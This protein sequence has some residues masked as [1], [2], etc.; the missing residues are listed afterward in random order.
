MGHW[1]DRCRTIGVHEAIR[2]STSIEVSRMVSTKL[3]HRMVVVVVVAVSMRAVH[4]IGAKII[5]RRNVLL[6]FVLCLLKG[7]VVGVHGSGGKGRGKGRC[8]VRGDLP[9]G[10]CRCKLG[11]QRRVDE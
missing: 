2:V 11:A 3:L 6:V 8:I 4:A 1:K 5:H 7:G 10:G 9:L